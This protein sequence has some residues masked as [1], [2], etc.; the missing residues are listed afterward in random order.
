MDFYMPASSDAEQSL[1]Y[2]QS[3]ASLLELS[4]ALYSHLKRR[5]PSKLADFE[6][7]F[8][9]IADRGGLEESFVNREKG[10]NFNPKPA[11]ICQILLTESAF[12]DNE[13]L[14]AA[15][16]M[17]APIGDPKDLSVQLSNT[18]S[19]AATLADTAQQVLNGSAP[20]SAAE[21][22]LAL[23]SALDEA[24]HLHLTTLSAAQRCAR[25]QDLA[26]LLSFAAAFEGTE[27]LCKLLQTAL[28][29]VMKKHSDHEE[30]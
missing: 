1:F 17:A 6:V 19:Q 9:W 10:V 2:G 5:V 28:T 24:R 21:Y 4:P 16:F 26:R 25:A 23:A 11:R 14:L 27:R 3:R 29:R 18:F 8:N 30:G 13:I 20:H 7:A 15:L 12:E 22:A